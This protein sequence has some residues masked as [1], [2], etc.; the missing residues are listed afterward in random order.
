MKTA[1]DVGKL[2]RL[3]TG[4]ALKLVGNIPVVGILHQ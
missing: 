2:E 3:T 1:V 4:I